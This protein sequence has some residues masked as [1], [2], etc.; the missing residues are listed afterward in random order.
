MT[1][2]H[3]TVVRVLNPGLEMVVVYRHMTLEAI[4]EAERITVGAEAPGNE[5]PSIGFCRVVGPEVATGNQELVA[6][7]IQGLVKVAAQVVTTNER[8]I[9]EG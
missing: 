1:P 2:E 3:R 9:S 6:Q 4:Q 8:S 7:M 5:E